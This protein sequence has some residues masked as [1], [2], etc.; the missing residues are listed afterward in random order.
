MPLR[1]LKG[2]EGLIK[3]MAL[4]PDGQILSV[5]NEF[6]MEVSHLFEGSI[7][8]TMEVDNTSNVDYVAISPDGQILASLWQYEDT[9]HIWQISDGS[10]LQTISSPDVISLAFSPDGQTLASG[11]IDT[12]LRLWRVSDGALLR[13]LDKPSSWRANWVSSIAFSADGQTMASAAE[14]A[15][16]RLWR[17]SD[18][19]LL[20]ELKGYEDEDNVILRLVALSPDAQFLASGSNYGTLQLWRISDGKLLHTYESQSKTYDKWSNSD[21]EGLSSLAFSPDGQTLAFSWANEVH[22]LR[23]SDGAMLRTL[24]VNEGSVR[25]LSFSLD[26]QTLAAVLDYGRVQLWGLKVNNNGFNALVFKV[27]MNFFYKRYY[28]HRLMFIVV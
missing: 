6:S 24:L 26:G 11:S 9:I 15:Q 8:N 10:L 12:S 5:V 23:V 28:S 2:R 18:G 13:I 19:M 25:L 1:S 17:V 14:Y 22:L 21:S 3:A 4:S 27:I 20:Y 16:V 7:L